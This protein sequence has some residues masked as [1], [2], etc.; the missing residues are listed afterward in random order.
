MATAFETFFKAWGQRDDAARTEAIE[1]AMSSG[2]VYADPRSPGEVSD[3]GPLADY[4]AAFGANAP[5]WIAEV[6]RDDTTQ[7]WHR[8][9]VEFGDG[10]Q[11]RQHGTYFGKLDAAGRIETLVGFVGA[12]EL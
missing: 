11:M 9:L 8:L 3:L 4:V 12:G 7:G 1:G 2:F 10:D 5:G 6:K